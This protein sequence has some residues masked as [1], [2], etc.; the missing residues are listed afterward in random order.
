MMSTLLAKVCKPW[1]QRQLLWPKTTLCERLKSLTWRAKVNS[2]QWPPR[3]HQGSSS[4]TIF[5]TAFGGS[6]RRTDAHFILIAWPCLLCPDPKFTPQKETQICCDMFHKFQIKELM[7]CEACKLR[8]NLKY[9][10]TL[11]H[12]FEDYT[13]KILEQ[14]SAYLDVMKKLYNIG[15]AEFYI[16]Y[17][18]T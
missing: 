6:P 2:Y 14:C 8:G 13:T 11:I 10:D 12:I 5:F 1:R 18:T 9:M 15:F 4:N 16:D 3:R 17:I 7:V